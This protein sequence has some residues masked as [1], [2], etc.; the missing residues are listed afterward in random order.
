MTVGEFWNEQKFSY[1]ATYSFNR[2]PKLAEAM[3]QAIQELKAARF[4]QKAAA[5]RK[6]ERLKN[7]SDKLTDESG[8][9]HVTAIQLAEIHSQSVVA[10]QLGAIFTQASKQD[11]YAM[12]W[13]IYRDAFVFYNEK[14]AVVRVLNICFECNY[15]ATDTGLHVEADAAT[16][17]RLSELIVQLGHTIESY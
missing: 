8:K 2:E 16:Y 13:P 11:V 4:M 7:R 17:Q 3:Q 12:F 5:Q 1:L 15:M 10:Q 6:I 14:R 9:L